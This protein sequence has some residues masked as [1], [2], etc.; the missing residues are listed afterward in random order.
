MATEITKYQRA[1]TFII[2]EPG[3]AARY[4]GI[5]VKRLEHAFSWLVA[6][7]AWKL[8]FNFTE[9]SFIAPGY[10]QEKASM[11][12]GDAD[13]IELAKCVAKIVPHCE[14]PE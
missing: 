10:I 3:N 12:I 7:P 13:A 6:F 4:E 2:H 1:V 14:G 9:G 11:Y 8:T 5:A